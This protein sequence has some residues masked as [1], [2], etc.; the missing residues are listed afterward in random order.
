MTEELFVDGILGV[1]FGKGAVRVDLF[2]MSADAVDA[3]GHPVRERRQRLIMTTEG[4]IESFNLLAD[5]MEKLQAQGLVPERQ[6]KPAP[7]LRDINGSVSPS[8]NF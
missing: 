2:T 8:P 5:V 6:P 1:G 4:F 7:A 3:N